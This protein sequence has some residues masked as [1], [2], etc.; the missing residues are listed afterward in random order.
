MEFSEMT[1]SPVISEG[2]APK[3]SRQ[4]LVSHLPSIY[5]GWTTKNKKQKMKQVV[6]CSECQAVKKRCEGVGDCT[7][8]A[9]RGLVCVAI[10]RKKRGPKRK[11][12]V[13]RPDSLVSVNDVILPESQ[14]WP[15]FFFFFFVGLL[16]RNSLLPSVT[17]FVSRNDSN[18]IGY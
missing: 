16:R 8:C 18:M 9:T 12:E 3:E 11:L 2:H 15:F 10:P 17:S 5:F 4:V 13:V 14:V 7:R 6:A 1:K